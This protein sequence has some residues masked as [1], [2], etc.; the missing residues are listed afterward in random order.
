MCLGVIGFI[1]EGP[2]DEINRF[3]FF[4]RLMGDQTK[5]MQGDGLI[6]VGLQYLLI[7]DLGLGQATRRV[8]LQ[9]KVQ[10]LLDVWSNTC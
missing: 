5:Q 1:G 10:D 3:V 8:L 9:G 4:P 6:G 2:C 7:G